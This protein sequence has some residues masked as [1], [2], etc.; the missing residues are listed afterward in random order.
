MKRW[1]TWALVGAYLCSKAAAFLYL[2][3]CACVCA[4]VL[5]LYS[6]PVEAV[7]YAFIL[8]GALLALLFVRGGFKYA[9]RHRKVQAAIAQLDAGLAELPAPRAL[10]ERD[11][12]ALAAALEHSRRALTLAADSA[13]QD[14]EKYY[15]LWAHQIKTPIAAM[16]LLLGQEDTPQSAALSAEL[17]RV[18]QYVEMALGYLRVDSGADLVLAWHDL[19]DLVRQAVRRYAPLFVRKKIALR[20]EPVHCR[21]LTDEKWLVF[22]LE[23]LLSNALKYTE[24]GSIT[25]VL[26]PGKRLQ[27][28][29][30]GIGIQPEDLPRVFEKG[31]T[32]YNGRAD[33]RA[34]GIGLYLCRRIAQ[35]LG[36]TITA[37]SEVGV[38]TTVTLG[39]EEAKLE[40]E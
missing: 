6:L 12:Q 32:G 24:R 22:L 7:A 40:V 34:T 9:A 17:L 11:Y 20:Y 37:E 27:V 8:C 36:H 26:A 3:L 16:K 31:Y 2:A 35:K 23:Q 21:V 29:D 4:A 10:L 25:I 30:T 19:D 15:T 13:R 28:R 38:G 39:L 5:A 1:D 33:K 18:E 14:T